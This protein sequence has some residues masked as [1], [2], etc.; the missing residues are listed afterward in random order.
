MKYQICTHYDELLQILAGDQDFHKT[1][2]DLEDVQDCKLCKKNGLGIC[3]LW[4]T[5]AATCD[6]RPQLGMEEATLK[7]ENLET[8]FHKMAMQLVMGA[9]KSKQ[10]DA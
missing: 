7:M 2:F 10:K 6:L 1:S 9:A 4:L 8:E 3:D 5:L